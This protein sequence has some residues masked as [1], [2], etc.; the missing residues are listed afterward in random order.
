MEKKKNTDC[1][2][3]YKTNIKN[4]EACTTETLRNNNKKFRHSSRPG[5]PGRADSCI[6][7]TL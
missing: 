7:S 4:V 1:L 6:F 3:R 5:P 2:F